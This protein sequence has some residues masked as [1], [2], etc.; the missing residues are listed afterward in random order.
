MFLRFTASAC[1]VLL[2]ASAGAIA[3][4]DQHAEMQRVV[5]GLNEF[6]LQLSRKLPNKDT[7][8]VFYS[9]FSIVTALAMTSEGAEGDTRSEFD[10]V[11]GNGLSRDAASTGFS[12]MIAAINRSSRVGDTQSFE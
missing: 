11:I 12:E 7:D 2:F 5:N 4:T 8:N 10:K 3:E 6:G 1:L 9:P